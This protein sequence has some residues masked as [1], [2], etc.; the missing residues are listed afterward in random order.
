MKKTNRRTD[1]LAFSSD[2][3]KLSLYPLFINTV[4]PHPPQAVPLPPG[5]GK[6]IRLADTVYNC[7]TDRMLN[8]NLSFLFKNNPSVTYR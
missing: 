2:S 7:Y 8:Y 6:A 1:Y 5:Q 4:Q 3:G